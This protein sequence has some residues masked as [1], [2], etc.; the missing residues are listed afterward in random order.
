[1]ASPAKPQTRVRFYRFRNALKEKLMGAGAGAGAQAAVSEEALAKVEANLK[2]MAEDYPD[3]VMASVEKLRELHAR[4][5]DTVTDRKRNYDL[6]RGQAFEMKGQG[7]TFGYPLISTFA[8]SL[9]DTT[10]PGAQDSDATVEIIKSHVDSIAAVIKERVK[11]P[12]GDIGRDL[13]AGLKAAIEKH[14]LVA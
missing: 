5:V 10:G 8:S 9:Y 12:G 4:C 3:W 6:I 7:G 11:G 14:S 1:M 13:A 2:D